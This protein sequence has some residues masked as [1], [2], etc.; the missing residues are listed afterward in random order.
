MTFVG[1]QTLVGKTTDQS[2]MFKNWVVRSEWN[3][4]GPAEHFDWWA[5]PIDRDSRAHGDRYNITPV[6]EQL[7]SHREFLTAVR[8]NAE[9]LMR[10]WGWDI[11]QSAG[12]ANRYPG[13]GVRLW[14]CGHSLHLLGMPVA[15]ASVC[16]FADEHSESKAR[17]RLIHLGPP[18]PNFHQVD[19]T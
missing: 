5:F 9:L 12:F 15:F 18:S 10:A 14:K 7:R 11:H 2:T 1:V 19:V 13:Y 17:D 3:K 6:L 4:F 16:R 8:D